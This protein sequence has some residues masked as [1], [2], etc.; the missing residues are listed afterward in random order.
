MG[1]SIELV[2]ISPFTHTLMC[3][4]AFV[5]V[6]V[7]VQAILPRLTLHYHYHDQDI[8]SCHDKMPSPN[9][10]IATPIPFPHHPQ[11]LA[12]TNSFFT[13]K[14]ILLHESYINEI[15]QYVSF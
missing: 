13:S 5:C 15:M 4:H 8:S 6:S 2:Q 14:I 3:I 12:T 10:F 11:L 7:H 1:T 9:P